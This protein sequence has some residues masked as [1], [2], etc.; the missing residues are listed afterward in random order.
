M[1]W[2][3]AAVIPLKAA[4]VAGIPRGSLHARIPVRHITGMGPLCEALGKDDNGSHKRKTLCLLARGG[5]RMEGDACL[6]GSICTMH[7]CCTPSNFIFGTVLEALAT[8]VA[9]SPLIYG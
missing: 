7:C 2:G 4:F 6:G 1:C 9:R 3:R 8:L 5:L